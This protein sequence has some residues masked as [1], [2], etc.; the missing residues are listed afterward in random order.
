MQPWL[1]WRHVVGNTYGTWLPGDERGFR[2]RH[3]REHVEGD[4]RNRPPRQ[5]DQWRRD[6]AR[7]LMKRDAVLLTPA[8]R[9]LVCRAIAEKVLSFG[10]EVAELAVME[11]HFHAL[12]RFDV[13]QGPRMAI[14]GLCPDNALA[15]GRDPVPRHVIGVAKKHATHM[16]REAGLK[17]WQ[18][19]LWARRPH[20]IPV[21]DAD[22]FDFLRRR[23]L[24]DHVREGGVLWSELRRG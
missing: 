15:D 7:R 16:L 8:M 12:C 1:G 17:S 22:H 24:P 6:H 18:G 9:P 3:H 11:K 13:E 14:R 10:F 19:T 23:Y 20:I 4:Y 2:T 21:E 5:R